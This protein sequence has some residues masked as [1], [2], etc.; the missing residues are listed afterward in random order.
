MKTTF[1]IVCNVLKLYY[2]ESKSLR[3]ISSKINIH[4]NTVKRIC[5]T[6]FSQSEIVLPLLEDNNIEELQKVIK[7]EPKH[8]IRRK[9]NDNHLTLIAELCNKS[10]L[11][12]S[13]EYRIFRKSS[14]YESAPVA[15]V[16]FC[17]LIKD[18]Q[19]THKKN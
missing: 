9:V 16:T 5:D 1:E 17:R 18:F 8:Q 13:K 3:Y 10:D 4:R 7:L 15:F 19:S 14:L 12:I 11:N 2:V 6:Y